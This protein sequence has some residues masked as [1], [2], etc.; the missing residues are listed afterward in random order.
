MYRLISG[1]VVLA[2]I[3]SCNVTR[4][5]KPLEKGEHRV[6]GSFGGPAIIFSGA[7]I[8]IPFS[9]ISYAHGLDTG[10]T[11]AGGIHTTA[12]L[13]G[14]LEMDATLGI[15][16]YESSGGR[17]GI[18]A[19]PGVNLFYGLR[20]NDFRVYPNL[21][22][23]AWWKYSDKDHLLYGGL[24]TWVELRRDKAHGE[25]QQNELMPYITLG[26]QFGGEKWHWQVEAR[27]IGFTYSNDDIVV[28]YLGPFANGTSGVYVGLTRTIGKK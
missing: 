6:G 9:S 1:M 8:P 27:Y 20:G 7:P 21:D 13:F 16:A 3:A 15:R 19:S 14:N 11:V 23:T 24:G 12:L 18:T 4:V 10:F 17:F 25:V 26:H 28:N 22:G 5:V 2:L